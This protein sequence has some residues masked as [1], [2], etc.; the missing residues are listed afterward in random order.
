MEIMLADKNYE[1]DS[2]SNAK[3]LTGFD[4]KLANNQKEIHVDLSN[5]IPKNKSNAEINQIREEIYTSYQAAID[6]SPSHEKNIFEKLAEKFDEGIS[7]RSPDQDIPHHVNTHVLYMQGKPNI[8]YLKKFGPE[9]YG[10]AFMELHKIRVRGQ[11]SY[12]E[13][14]DP[15]M[16][17]SNL[18]ELAASFMQSKELSTDQKHTLANLVASNVNDKVLSTAEHQIG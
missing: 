10:E 12:V 1:T 13:I 2:K 3:M 7:W 6:K 11:E 16:S 9:N 4:I 15:K 8:E 18:Q 14:A 5:Y 17:Q